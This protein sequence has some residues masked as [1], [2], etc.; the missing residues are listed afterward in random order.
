MKMVGETATVCRTS[1]VPLTS[2]VPQ[3]ISLRVLVRAYL[4]PVHVSPLRSGLL[5]PS[6][7]QTGLQPAMQQHM[8]MQQGVQH[9]V[10]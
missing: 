2:T 4:S 6:V 1:N 3:Q 7:S 9:R 5:L 10:G 8:Q